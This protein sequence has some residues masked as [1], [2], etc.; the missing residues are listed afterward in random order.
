MNGEVLFI[1]PIGPIGEGYSLSVDASLREQTR[2]D[3]RLLVVGDGPSMVCLSGPDPRIIY[4]TT[5]KRAHDFGHTPRAYGLE[6][7]GVNSD[8]VVLTGADAYYTP[9][10]CEYMV[11]AFD[12]GTTAVYCDFVSRFGE[13]GLPQGHKDPRNATWDVIRSKLNRGHIDC[14]AVMVRSDRARAV[15]WTGRDYAADW[16]FIKALCDRF[17]AHTL[18][19]L[20]QVLYVHN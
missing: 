5:P 1:A 13:D 8:F 4:G 12:P 17:G 15:G 14:G 20:P 18:K 19:H 3:W 6:H 16:T 11:A 2:P 7:F 9:R 10:F